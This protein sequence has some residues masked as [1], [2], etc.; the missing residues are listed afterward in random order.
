MTRPIARMIAITT[1]LLCGVTALPAIAN[2]AD[3]TPGTD[4]GV[5]ADAIRIDAAA[6]FALGPG[7]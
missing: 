2:A 1:I 7:N 6:L 4:A 3:R 5:D